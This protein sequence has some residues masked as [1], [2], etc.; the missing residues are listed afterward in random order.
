MPSYLFIT[1]KRNYDGGQ[2]AAVLCTGKKL[3]GGPVNSTFEN[4]NFYLE[5]S[6]ANKS[7]TQPSMWPS[8]ENCIESNKT[9]SMT[10]FPS[11]PGMSI[12]LAVYNL[13]FYNMSNC[14]ENNRVGNYKLYSFFLG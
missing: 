6:T 11:T 4:G 5:C 3:L 2:K 12:I 8:Q 14:F 9:C 13:L 7:W 1:G 10:E